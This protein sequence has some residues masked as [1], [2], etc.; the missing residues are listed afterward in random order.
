M[1]TA[2]KLSIRFFEYI[3]K[4]QDIAHKKRMEKLNKK[5]DLLFSALEK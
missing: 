3:Y 1:Q 2:K 4:K 5:I